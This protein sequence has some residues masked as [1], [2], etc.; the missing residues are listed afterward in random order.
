MV[1]FLIVLRYNGKD[2]QESKAL[3]FNMTSAGEETEKTKCPRSGGFERG[4]EGIANDV[5]VEIILETG[6][7]V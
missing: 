5:K 7:E 2:K 1:L 3:Q 6:I 4:K